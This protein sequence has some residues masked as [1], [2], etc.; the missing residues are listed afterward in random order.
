[1]SLSE[2]L[3]VMRS[4]QCLCSSDTLISQPRLVGQTPRPSNAAIRTTQGHQLKLLYYWLIWRVLKL[5]FSFS[6]KYFFLYLFWRLEQSE[7]HHLWLDIFFMWSLI[8]RWRVFAKKRQIKNHAKLTSYTVTGVK[9]YGITWSRSTRAIKLTT[10]NVLGWTEGGE[11]R[12]KYW[13]YM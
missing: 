11:L 5:A 2:R 9:G 8:W 13:I 6:K 4:V 1:M 7:Q 3:P 10:T 12:P